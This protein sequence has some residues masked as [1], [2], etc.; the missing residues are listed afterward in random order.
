MLNVR[1]EWDENKNRVNIHKH[2]VSFSEAMTV[3][4]DP[5]VLYKPDPDH[6]RQEE[7]YIVL[8][9][10]EKMRILIVCHCYYESDLIIRIISARK[11]T[12]N[13]TDQYRSGAP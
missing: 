3:F 13:E 6:S 12:T 11:A 10:S 8:G 5:N 1:F 7:R 9:F 4:D 2:G